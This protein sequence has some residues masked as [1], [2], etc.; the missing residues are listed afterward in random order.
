MPTVEMPIRMDWRSARTPPVNG[1]D[2]AFAQKYKRLN[3]WD[4]DDNREVIEIIRSESAESGLIGTLKR[5]MAEGAKKYGH[6]LRV[7]DDTRQYNSRRDSWVEH[8]LQEN[9]DG[10]VY[11]GCAIARAERA[12]R[13]TANLRTTLLHQL[14]MC[15]SLRQMLKEETK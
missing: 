3:P 6:G 2:G 8:A 10:V 15:R 13:Q 5:R 12:G 1:F 7:A 14:A 9:L 4:V 11:L